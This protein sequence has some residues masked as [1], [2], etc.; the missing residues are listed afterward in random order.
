MGGK[1]RRKVRFEL[2][3]RPPPRQSYIVGGVLLSSLV[4]PP[5][6]CD[7]IEEGRRKRHFRG[8]QCGVWRRRVKII[9][10]PW[11]RPST[12]LSLSLSRCCYIIHSIHASCGRETGTLWLSTAR[13]QGNLCPCCVP[14]LAKVPSMSA[15]TS[16]CVVPQKLHATALFMIFVVIHPLTRPMRVDCW[17][18]PMTL[19]ISMLD[20]I[21]PAVRWLRLFRAYA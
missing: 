12:S 8:S 20:G 18:N 16:L 21:L 13:V 1:T 2:A 17:S 11:F 19:G 6:W 7:L 10:L 5:D 15:T 4:V 3:R 9:Y 14:E